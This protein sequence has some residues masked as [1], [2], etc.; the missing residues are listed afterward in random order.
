MIFCGVFHINSTFSVHTWYQ[1]IKRQTEKAAKPTS[2]QGWN[3]K[4]VFGRFWDHVSSST[5]EIYYAVNVVGFLWW[6]GSCF[7]WYACH[8]SPK[9]E[10]QLG[11]WLFTCYL[12]GSPTPQY[13]ESNCLRQTCLQ[14]L[15]W[16]VDN[17]IVIFSSQSPRVMQESDNVWLCGWKK[18]PI[19]VTSDQCNHSTPQTDN[20]RRHMRQNKCDECDFSS[21]QTNILQW[22]CW[23]MQEGGWKPDIVSLM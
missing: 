21:L 2:R 6:V 9:E 18:M 5:S 1:L 10:V 17:I 14:I 3:K 20:L 19:S 15:E 23:V 8:P 13:V 7:R 11:N 12:A 16:F 4:H 22:M